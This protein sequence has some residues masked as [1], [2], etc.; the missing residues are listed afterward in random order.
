MRIASDILQRNRARSTECFAGEYRTGGEGFENEPFGVVQSALD[1]LNANNEGNT[2][3]PAINRLIGNDC[4]DTI[5]WN[6]S[7]RCEL[8]RQ[9]NVSRRR[10]GIED[11][12]VALLAFRRN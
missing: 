4:C 3:L 5:L 7:N 2:C 8:L 12:V 10:R 1:E 9:G 11:Q 6:C